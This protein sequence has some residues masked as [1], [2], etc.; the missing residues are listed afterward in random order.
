IPIWLHAV[1]NFTSEEARNNYALYQQVQVY[2][3]N[4]GYPQQFN[5]M[6]DVIN[7]YQTIW[8]PAYQAEY[9]RDLQTLR[10]YVRAQ[11]EI[12]GIVPL[13]HSDITVESVMISYDYPV[14][15]GVNPLPDIFDSA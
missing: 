13:Y 1:P 15:Q 12:T 10:G 8:L 9:Q 2:L 7:Y 14:D 11:Q 4:V 5:N 6:G 3:T